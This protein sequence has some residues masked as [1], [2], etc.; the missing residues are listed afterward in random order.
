MRMLRL[1]L[2]VLTLA[3]GPLAACY[4]RPA[5]GG[6][7]DQPAWVR[8][9]NRSFTDATVYVWPSS[10]RLRIG[11]VSATSTQTLQLPRSVIFGPTSLRFSVD[12]LAGNRS[13]LTESITVVPGDTVVLQIPPGS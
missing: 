8:V 13:P 2:V 4:H 12:F 7:P 6:S 9:D 5:S 11:F 10:Q 1:S 3:L